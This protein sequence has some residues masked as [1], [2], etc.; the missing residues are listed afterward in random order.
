MYQNSI[1][2]FVIRSEYR[3]DISLRFN[4]FCSSLDSKR[5]EIPSLRLL[6]L[7][8]VYTIEVKYLKPR[9]MCL[10]SVRNYR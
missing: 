7:G 6:D 5:E 9:T 10:V 4:F 2:F 8:K 3:K 1:S